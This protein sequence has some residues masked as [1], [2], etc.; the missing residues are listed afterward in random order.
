MIVPVS[1]ASK[2]IRQTLCYD[3]ENTC[4]SIIF[5]L[6]GYYPGVFKVCNIE[7]E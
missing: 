4:F 2:T 1:R 6:S 5:D 7:M 3:L